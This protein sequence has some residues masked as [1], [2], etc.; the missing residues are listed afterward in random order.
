MAQIIPITIQRD[1]LPNNIDIEQA[2]LGALLASNKIFYDVDAILKPEHFFDPLHGRVYRAIGELITNGDRADPLTL[3]RLFDQDGALKDI[4][5]AEYLVRLAGSV[6]TLTD[7]EGY[8]RIIADLHVKRDMIYL[9][10]TMLQELHIESYGMEPGGRAADLIERFEGQLALIADKA[11]AQNSVIKAGD[12]LTSALES[13]ERARKSPEGITGLATGL[14]D[15]DYRTGGIHPGLYIFAGR[16]GMG[17]TSLAVCVAIY[18]ARAA[19]LRGRGGVFFASLEMGDTEIGQKLLA[20]ITNI[21]TDDQRRGQINDKQ[22]EALHNATMDQQGLALQLDVNASATPSS[23]M[24]RARR[25]QKRQGLDLIVID[26]IQLMEGEGDGRD[27]GNRVQQVSRITR[28]LKKM[29]LSLNVPV[30]ALSQLSRKV[31]DRDDK[32]PNL[33]DLRDSGSIEQDADAVLFIYREEYY[34]MKGVPE[35][36]EHESDAKYQ[37]RTE[38]YNKRLAHSRNRAELILAKCRMG[39]TA[40]VDARF[41]GP[42]GRF[43]NYRADDIYE[44]QR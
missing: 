37:D 15:F 7:V 32:R 20:L 31:E 33:A 42:T 8:A 4:G 41:N 22:F 39:P 21:G 36:G 13:V 23:I 27:D 10:A 34:L 28:A 11:L 16:P 14:S 30:I 5:G 44:D 29:S 3:K 38:R 19:A 6:V 1:K 26:Y 17:K 2:L 25:M 35:Q 12:A 40:T 24:S 43:T 18:I 9:A